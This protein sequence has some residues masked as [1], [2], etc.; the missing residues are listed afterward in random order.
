LQ[1]NGAIYQEDWKNAQIAIFDPGITGNLT[2]SAN[3]GDYRVRG[4]ETSVVARVTP[5]L[6]VDAGASWNRSE[7]VK[8]ATL[9]WGTGRDRF[10]QAGTCQSRRRPRQSAF[11]LTAVPGNIRARYDFRVADYDLLPARRRASGSLTGDDRC[12]TKDL[13]GTPSRTIFPPTRP[14]MGARIAR[15]A[16]TVQLFGENLSDKRAELYAN[17]RQWYKAVTT[18]R[19]RTLACDSATG[20]GK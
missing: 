12:L 19:P 3:G 8:L 5:Q 14:S 10:F 15:D 13:Q 17:N 9:V 1:F 7:L 11:G 4:L 2:F 20:F 18:N 16:W 6:T